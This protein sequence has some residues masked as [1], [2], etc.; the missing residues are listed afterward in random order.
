MGDRGVKDWFGNCGKLQY[1]GFLA[2]L[3]RKHG[4]I[5]GQNYR[6]V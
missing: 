4:R 1:G 3:L 2:H 6:M 5:M